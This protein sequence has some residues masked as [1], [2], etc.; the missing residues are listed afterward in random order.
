MILKMDVHKLKSLLVIMDALKYMNQHVKEFEIYHMLSLA[1]MQE[2][3]TCEMLEDRRL[4]PDNR[5]WLE[6][7]NKNSKQ[8]MKFYIGISF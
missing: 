5:D 7:V 3:M 8:L 2:G 1:T 4:S 6:R